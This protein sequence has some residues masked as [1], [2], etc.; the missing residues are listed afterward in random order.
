MLFLKL[1]IIGLVIASGIYFSFFKK[2]PSKAQSYTL[3]N[4]IEILK[5]LGISLNENVTIDDFLNSFDRDAYEDKPFDL[6]LFVYGIEIESEPWG[7]NFSNN[8]WNFDVECIEDNGSYIEIV[9]NFALLSNKLDEIENIKDS[10]DFEK[11]DAWVSYSINGIEKRYEAEFDNDWADPITVTSIMSDLTN[12]GY[13]F[14]AKDNGQ[15]SIWFY[16]D[17][18]TAQKLNEYSNNALVKN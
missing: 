15:A 6:I 7:R 5:G 10:V 4:Q 9:K 17:D 1:L 3:E 14:Y 11:E 13:S 2:V 8:A 12:D 18:K 16:L